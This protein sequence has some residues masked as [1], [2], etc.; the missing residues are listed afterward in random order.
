[1]ANRSLRESVTF[2]NAT[3]ALQSAANVGRGPIADIAVDG[4]TLVVTNFADHSVAVLDAERLTVSGGLDARE[5]FALAVAGD[6]AYVGVA[7][8][9]YDA[10][11]V[12]DT[13]TGAI[14]AS[15]PLSFSVTAMT[16][17]PDGKRIYAGRA[18]DGGVD[19]AIIDVTT[20]RVGTIYLA[21]GDDTVIDAMRVDASGRRLYVATSMPAA[22][23]WSSSTSRTRGFG[24][25]WRSARP[26]ADS[27]SAWTARPT[28]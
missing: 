8:V 20:D 1:M 11:A 3:A 28:C 26:S 17:S 12:V 19:V 25:R 27:R 9:A 23:A 16:T 10:I 24:A 5:P 7:S 21:K 18:A 2:E 13:H 4:D 15:Y 22:A 6:R 14:V